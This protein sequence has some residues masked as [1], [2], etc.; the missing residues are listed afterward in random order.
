[1]GEQRPE[2]KN[3]VSE[4]P[5]R[6][7]QGFCDVCDQFRKIVKAEV[8]REEGGGTAHILLC[9]ACLEDARLTLEHDIETEERQNDDEPR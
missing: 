9:A 7:T 4:R 1:M 2:R 6:A 5:W 3:V 8:V